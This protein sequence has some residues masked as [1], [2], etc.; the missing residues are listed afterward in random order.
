MMRSGVLARKIGMSGIFI[1]KERV[2]IT[3][4]SVDGVCVV[5][6]RCVSDGKFFLQIGIGRQ[7]NP[8]KPLSGVYSKRGLDFVPEKVREF[9]VD[10]SCRV[11]VGSLFSSHHFALGQKV[12]VSGVT[13]G[14]GFAGGMKRWNF[15]GLRASHGV[16]I[17]HR[18]LG[19]TGQRQD[20]GR[21]FKGK[22]MAGHMGVRRVTVQSLSVVFLDEEGKV[23]GLKGGV[24]GFDGSYVE[25]RDAVKRKG[26]SDLMVP[27]VFLGENVASRGGV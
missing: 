11:E 3:L 15:G 13:V 10:D 21:V 19:S 22:K 6:E 4:F 25:V 26:A 16:S 18:S 9:L 8:S 27:G 24:P 2:P 23:F 7:K 5:G 14:R 17:S 12:D 1:G 20:P